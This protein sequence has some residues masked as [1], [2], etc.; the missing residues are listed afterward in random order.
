MLKAP[1]WEAPLG[2]WQAGPGPVTERPGPSFMRLH[3]SAATNDKRLIVGGPA[4]LLQNSNTSTPLWRSV[5]LCLQ[6]N[7]NRGRRGTGNSEQDIQPS[8]HNPKGFPQ[9]FIFT[10]RKV[11]FSVNFHCI[12]APKPDTRSTGRWRE[13]GD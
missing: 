11:G 7:D 12:D 10:D 9:M 4:D 2:S 3:E 5:A 1:A 13:R 8:P 6:R